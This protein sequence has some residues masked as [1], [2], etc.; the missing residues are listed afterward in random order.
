MS[1]EVADDLEL[2]VAA[3]INAARADAGLA[4][5]KVEA[6]LNSAA[7]DHSD[8]MGD[9]GSPLTHDGEDGSTPTDRIG[10]SGFPLTGSWGTAENI[11][12]RTVVGD[13][14]NDDV[15][16]LHQTLMNSPDHLANIMNPDVS[17]VGIGLSVGQVDGIP[18]DAAILTEDFGETDGRTLV[19]EEQG[20]ETVYQPYQDGE[21][22]GE[23]QPA[24]AADET[25]TDNPDDPNPD[26]P[27]DQQAR[28]A[29]SGCF[30]ATAAY[31]SYDHPDVVALRRFKDEVLDRS[32]AG[33][34]FVSFYWYV[35]PRL[36]R[37]VSTD[38]ISGRVAR[39]LIAPLARRAARRETR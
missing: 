10:D 39:S 23:P 24:P 26:D 20:G 30:V 36:A 4:P 25:D 8:W 31:G 16:A 11:A 33:R 35:G 27:D 1:T 34:A 18:G 29:S 22:V 19:Q 2:R 38:G 37:R 28:E 15:D 7:Q 32:V 17:Y 12:A 6:H 14:G 13:L 9:T 5:L 3:S 21:P